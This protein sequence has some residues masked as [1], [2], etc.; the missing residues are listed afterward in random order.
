MQETQATGGFVFRIDHLKIRNGR[1]YAWGWLFH[2]SKAIVSLSL[3]LR[4]QGVE[5][6][7]PS[8]L[9]LPRPDVSSDY[10]YATALNSGFIIAGRVP[11]RIDQAFL[12]VQLE[13][14]SSSWLDISAP[15]TKDSAR[16]RRRGWTIIRWAKGTV[17][18]LAA[19]DLKGWLRQV[20]YVLREN[21]RRG[22]RAHLRADDIFGVVSRLSKEAHLSVVIDHNLGGGANAYRQRLIE[23]KKRDGVPVLLVYYHL[24]ELEYHGRLI[25]PGKQQTFVM[26]PME[27]LL[28]LSSHFKIQEIFLNNV[29][30]FDDPLF[31][32]TL[33]LRVKELTGAPLTVAVHDFFSICPSYALL[34][35]KRQFCGIP[36]TKK[37][38]R[39][40][41]ENKADFRLLVDCNDIT[42]WRQTWGNVLADATT[43]LCFSR[44]SA[45]LLYRAYPGLDKSKTI[46]RPHHVN[47]FYDRKPRI[48]LQA[49][50]NIGV[51]GTISVH[52]GAA[53]VEEMAKLIERRRLPVRITVIGEMDRPI[54]SPAVTVTGRYRLAALPRIIEKGKVN[55]F[56]LPSIWPETFCYVAEE[57]MM[58]CVPLAVFGLG[59]QAERVVNYSKGLIIPQVD[60][61]TAL[62]ELIEFYA[63]LRESRRGTS[64]AP[65]QPATRRNEP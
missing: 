11:Q 14:G 44:S 33:L 35:E 56:F 27:H 51:V 41:L 36:Q 21:L 64:R 28:G 50:L 9:G 52:K 46:I 57:L 42:E 65:Q 19:G 61:E 25:W 6:H 59:A 15:L 58:L 37:C 43:I 60:A 30:S 26:N 5:L 4:G 47:R 63:K 3:V 8:K 34:N 38:R 23:E 45:D 22:R 49:P 10:P 54:R 32:L 18:Y 53:I 13:D 2:K 7:I 31:F 55:V 24:P 62:N 1:A 29:F 12:D 39:C 48:D 17:K 40:L 20:R 16:V